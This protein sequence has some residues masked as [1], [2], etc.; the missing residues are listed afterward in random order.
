MKHPIRTRGLLLLVAFVLGIEVWAVNRKSTSE[1][2]RNDLFPGTG[3]WVK[4]RLPFEDQEARQ[5][6]QAGI[7]L[8]RD[9][10]SKKAL[11]IYKKFTK[12]RTDLIINFE[13]NEVLIGPEAIYRASLISEKLGDWK[14]AFN[15]LE[16][17]AKAY[18]LYDFDRIADSLIRIAEKIATQ[19]LPKKWGF[20]PRLSSDSE[21]FGRFKKIVEVAKGPKYAPRALMVLSN[22]ALKH[23]KQEDA[24]EALEKITN[25]YP[26]HFLSEEALFMLAEIYQTKINGSSYDQSI[27]KKTR[28]YYELYLSLHD[29]TP[30]I[31]P[32][33]T[34]HEFQKR[35]N[36]WNERRKLATKQISFLK[37]Q[38]ALS[39]IEM[40]E[41]VEKY[42]KYFLVNW[43]ELGHGP[44]RN[45]YY[46]AKNYPGTKAAKLADKKIKALEGE[47]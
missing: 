12:R 8:E 32:S 23:G 15:Y 20:L 13:G 5:W 30:R 26:D 3:F 41:Y 38:L 22:L 18:V 35:E 25:F 27:T 31:A 44:A 34:D 9:G 43:K 37:E 19:P 11:K 14:V 29:S 36:A 46:N 1:D 16:L 17:I 2:E 39:Q 28:D 47:K 42:G 7:Q 21:N 10:E 4:N 24:I 45:F 33:E 6:F 40:G